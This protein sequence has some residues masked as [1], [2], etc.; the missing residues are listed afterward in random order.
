MKTNNIKSF[1][2]NNMIELICK[3]HLTSPK[4]L[5]KSQFSHNFLEGLQSIVNVAKIQD[6]LNDFSENLVSLH[7]TEFEEKILLR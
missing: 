4:N 6:K 1:L 2:E 3:Y 7:L 5:D